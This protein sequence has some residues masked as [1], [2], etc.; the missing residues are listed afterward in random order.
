MLYLIY[1]CFFPVPIIEFAQEDGILSDGSIWQEILN[2]SLSSKTKMEWNHWSN[3]ESSGMLYEFA[4]PW[5]SL[6]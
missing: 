6:I 4:A 2:A 1:F 3:T 5:R